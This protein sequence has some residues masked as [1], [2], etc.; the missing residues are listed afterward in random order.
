MGKIITTMLEANKMT[1][2]DIVNLKKELIQLPQLTE[3]NNQIRE[4]LELT[5]QYTNNYNYYQQVVGDEL[6]NKKYWI[7][8]FND[9]NPTVPLG[10]YDDYIKLDNK[11]FSIPEGF[12]LN[13]PTIFSNCCTLLDSDQTGGDSN[14]IELSNSYF[15]YMSAA[16]YINDLDY[17]PFLRHSS[18]NSLFTVKTDN[19]TYKLSDSSTIIQLNAGETI[20]KISYNCPLKS[21]ISDL[22]HNEK[23]RKIY[24]NPV[25]FYS[26]Y[27][28]PPS[29]L[30][31]I[32]CTDGGIMTPID[33]WL[34]IDSDKSGFDYAYYPKPN[35]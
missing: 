34:T 31:R 6:L 24:F 11:I 2:R 22:Y 25:I 19:N 27:K 17:S 26:K 32:Y 18:S 13:T 10:I 5:S 15:W 14:R 30:P 35:K 1:Y 20:T 7:N 12:I 33:C 29:A 21:S 4:I 8:K 28:L 9:K 23:T 3:K 16:I